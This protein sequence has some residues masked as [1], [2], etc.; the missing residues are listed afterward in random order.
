MLRYLSPEIEQIY[1]NQP[2]SL[3]PTAEHTMSFEQLN[4]SGRMLLFAY[5]VLVAVFSLYTP[6][7][8]F[9]TR[10]YEAIIIPITLKYSSLLNQQKEIFHIFYQSISPCISLVFHPAIDPLETSWFFQLLGK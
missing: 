5:L 6:E 3:E 1:Q 8:V 7:I 10:R 9:A 4:I 2:L